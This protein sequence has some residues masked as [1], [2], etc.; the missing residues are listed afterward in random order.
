MGGGKG[1]GGGAGAFFLK[2]TQSQLVLPTGTK[3]SF[4]PD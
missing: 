3:R 4:N 2:K 1:I